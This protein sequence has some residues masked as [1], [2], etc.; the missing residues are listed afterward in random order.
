MSRS[1][2]ALPFLVLA[3]TLAGC[4]LQ[5]RAKTCVLATSASGPTK[6]ADDFTFVAVSQ[7]LGRAEEQMK[8]DDY[9]RANLAL[10]DGL[11]A[12]GRADFDARVAVLDDTG[13]HLALASGEE[14]KGNLE[15]AAV[16]RRSTLA[17]RL[18]SYAKQKNLQGCPTPAASLTLELPP[19]LE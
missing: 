4:G 17:D 12:L 10:R 15:T 16:I 19:P 3:A 13:T 1:L 2:P 6:C 11:E 5:A 7:D 9:R 8:L 18:A 14:W